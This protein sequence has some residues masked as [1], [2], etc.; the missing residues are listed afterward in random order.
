MKRRW[1]WDGLLI[2]V[3][4]LACY[5]Y[6]LPRWADWNQNSRFDLVRAIVEKGTLTI[7]DY[8]SNTGDY[9]TID[10]H[11]YSDKAP[12][13]AFAAVPIHAIAYAVMSIPATDGLLQRLAAN[14]A[15]GDTLRQG[16]S[17]LLIDKVHHVLG[18]MIATLF[19]IVL[20][21]AALGVLIYSFLGQLGMAR[22]I[23]VATPL[24]YGL[25][26]IAFPYS[27]EF[28]AHQF[29]AVLLFA[30]FYL[31]FLM[32]RGRI[33][34]RALPAIGF[35]LSYAVISEYPVALIALGIALYAAI[36]A[37][38]KRWIA[39]AILGGLPPLALWAWHNVAIFGTPIKFGYE[40]STLWQSEHSIGFL[41]LGAPTLESIWGITFDS[42]RGLYFTS[43][44]LLL[45]W[46]GLFLF[47]KAREHRGAMLVCSW[48]IV[49]F[50]L[51]NASSAMWQGGFSVGPRYL[52]PMLP[53]AAIPLAYALAAA[54]QRRRWLPAIVLFTV[55]SFAVIW[56]E[57]IGG[58]AF[59]DYTSNPLF[60]YSL[61]RLLTGD[62]ARNLGMIAG[63]R[64]W[65]SLI[66]LAA[67]IGVCL[68]QLSRR[69]A[70]QSAPLA[71]P[72][73]AAHEQ[74]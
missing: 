6:F 60:N 19:L 32:R 47:W 61:P 53:F 71:A 27:G 22:S 23:R 15:F 17:G 8:A 68:W 59:P 46:P 26:T 21:S 65:A 37:P 12:G 18:L 9:A 63:L 35:L 4:L 39:G 50:L 62:I 13:L 72:S 24:I 70:M 7:D 11:I 30:A 49:S 64:G 33:D 54:L 20:P 28:Y 52:V 58:Q 73:L 14:P 1:D 74:L 34:S 56:I 69:P 44:I 29:V 48:A 5:V 3:A 36:A 16:G 40:Y 45:M 38:D 25:A 31:A 55:W 10:G 43:P 41:S 42:Y 51:F 2:F 66:P 67:C 57:T